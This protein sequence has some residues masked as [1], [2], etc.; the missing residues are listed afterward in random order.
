MTVPTA[1][2]SEVRHT[3]SKEGMFW[4]KTGA[5]HYHAQLELSYKDRAIKELVV[6]WVLL[7]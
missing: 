7:T 1:A 4:P 6:C 2:L 5:T 3:V